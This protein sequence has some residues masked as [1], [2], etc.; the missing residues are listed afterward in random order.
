MIELKVSCSF[1]SICLPLLASPADFW[2]DV[3]K[4]FFWKT[5]HS[6]RFLD[7]NFD[8]TKGE[9]FIKCMEGASTNICYNVL[10]HNV[11]DRKL[12]DKVAFYWSVHVRTHTRMHAHTH[13]Q[14]RHT[15]D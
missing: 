8:V 10:D 14:T 1:R 7:Y 13:A 4:D 3:A 15:K 11:L 2:G 5:K 12:G 6:G 9:I